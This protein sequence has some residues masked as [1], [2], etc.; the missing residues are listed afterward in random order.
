I[1]AD[2][3]RAQTWRNHRRARASSIDMIP[4]PNQARA[5]GV[6][7]LIGLDNATCPNFG[8]VSLGRPFGP[9][10]CRND[11]IEL[12]GARQAQAVRKADGRMRK[13]HQVREGQIVRVIEG[14]FTRFQGEGKEVDERTAKGRVR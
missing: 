14:P 1:D 11:R 3:A 8:S 10:P 5:W 6:Y 2:S 7:S 4:N 13:H 12:A 9:L